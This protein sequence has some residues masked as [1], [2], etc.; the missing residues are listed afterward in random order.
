MK[1]NDEYDIL[2]LIKTI[3]K[4]EKKLKQFQEILGSNSTQPRYGTN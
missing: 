1:T 4:E 3:K 2:K